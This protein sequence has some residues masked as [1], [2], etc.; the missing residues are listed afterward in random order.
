[1]SMNNFGKLVSH[2]R[3]TAGERALREMLPDTNGSTRLSLLHVFVEK[4][5]RDEPAIL[6][7]PQAP[8]PINLLDLTGRY[9][10]LSHLLAD[11]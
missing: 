3:T 9:R 8:D 10:L 7:H 5:E 4:V 6:L 11:A 1:M 2:E